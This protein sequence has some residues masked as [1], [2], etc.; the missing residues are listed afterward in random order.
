MD[1]R[2]NTPSD[3]SVEF[4]TPVSHF[5]VVDKGGHIYY[6]KNGQGC[7]SA[8]F[9]INCGPINLRLISTPQAGIKV[10]TS[11]LTIHKGAALVLPPFEHNYPA[12][13]KVFDKNL[14]GPAAYIPA[15]GI[16]YTGPAFFGIPLWIRK[17]VL[18]HELGH[19]YYVDEIKADTYA[20]KKYLQAGGTPE[21]AYL[22]LSDYLR[23]SGHK[24]ERLKN[25]KKILE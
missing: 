16:I 23:H 10:R 9:K 22:A 19:Q 21:G 20:A 3:V 24:A 15:K 1:I 6:D 13:L 17:F 18:F 25:L 4:D 14:K 8:K 11:R 12:H 5:A 7:T 2:I